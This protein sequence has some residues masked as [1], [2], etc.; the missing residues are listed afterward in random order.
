MRLIDADELKRKIDTMTIDFVNYKINLEA[1]YSA[2]RY[3][4]TV[5]GWV[6]VKDRLPE[7]GKLALVYGS[8]GEMTVARHITG[9]EWIVPGMFSRVTHWM[10]MPEPPKEVT[11]DE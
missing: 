1:V 11:V 4:P 3:A 6:S 9:N 10:T 8:C 2:I 5:G 7:I